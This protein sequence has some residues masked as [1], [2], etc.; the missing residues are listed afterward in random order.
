MPAKFLGLPLLAWIPLLPILGA[1]LNLTIGR[2]LDRKWNHII[3]IGAVAARDGPAS[4]PASA[5]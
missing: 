2:R 1:F 3:S 4:S 5:C